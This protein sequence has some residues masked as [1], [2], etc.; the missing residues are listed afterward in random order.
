MPKRMKKM[1]KKDVI[2]LLCTERSTLKAQVY[3]LRENL[4]VL[5]NCYAMARQELERRGIEY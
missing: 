2:R 1:K 5:R 4:R 3:S